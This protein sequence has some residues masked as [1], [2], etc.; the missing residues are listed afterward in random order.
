MGPVNLPFRHHIHSHHHHN[1]HHQHHPGHLHHSRL[2]HLRLQLHRAV[3]LQHPHLHRHHGNHNHNH[4]N[5]HDNHHSGSL[6]LLSGL[7][8]CSRTVLCL[9]LHLRRHH[10]LRLC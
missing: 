4:N 1:H 7:R 8:T 6:N 5:D 10:L 2:Q 3:R 9:P